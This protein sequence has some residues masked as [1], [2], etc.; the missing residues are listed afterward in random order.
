MMGILKNPVV[1]YT[2][3]YVV[4][5]WSESEQHDLLFTNDNCLPF[6]NDPQG[7]DLNI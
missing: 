7:A 3:L 5:A 1:I 6:A 4:G 2:H